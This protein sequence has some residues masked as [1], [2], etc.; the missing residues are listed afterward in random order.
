M[1][2]R[3]ISISASDLDY[4]GWPGL[5]QQAGLNL[6][7]IHSSE[8]TPGQREV[9][10]RCVQLG[11][12]IEYLLHFTHSF[13]NEALYEA[14][15]DWFAMDILGQRDPRGNP[16][17][18]QP[19]VM[20]LAKQK[21]AAC[22][23]ELAPTTHRYHL[24]AGDNK[25]WCNCAPC[26]RYSPSDQNTL[27]MNAMLEGVRSVDPH[28]QL[29]YLAYLE[30]LPPPRLV[31]PA[32]GLF[33]EFAPYRRS[34]L[35]PLDARDCHINRHHVEALDELLEVFDADQAVVLEYWIDVSY[36]SNYRRPAVCVKPDPD[37][38]S[39][40]IRVYTEKGIRVITSFAVYMDQEYF[41]KCGTEAVLE[42]GKQ[43]GAM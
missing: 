16:C 13:M 2:Y 37:R 7:G 32:D 28:A 11:I 23:R 26:S 20:A 5:H 8:L 35:Q 14:H 33:L 27:L 4:A 38:L 36:W 10:D 12:A 30:T 19:E 17:I 42:Y 3:G 31:R 24:W 18:S 21:A 40:D 9:A 6:L 29:A 15:P 39:R 25:A 22:A 43:L 41:E 1:K 34:F